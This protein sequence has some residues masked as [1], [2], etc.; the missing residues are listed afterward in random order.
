MLRFVVALEAE[1]RPLIE[2]YRL[3][4]GG[5]ERG[6]KTF[7]RDDV[8]LI[9]AGIG[10]VAAA[11]A[12]SRLHGVTGAER[13]AVWIN[14]GIA[15]HGTRPVAEAVLAHKV[16][17]RAS[18]RAWYPP[19][20]FKP[21]CA[22]DQVTTVD[23]PERAFDLPG[24]FEMEASGFVPSAGRFAS[25]E[26]VHCVKIVSDGHSSSLEG[27]TPEVVRRLVASQLSTVEA[28]AEAC[29]SLSRELRRVDAEA[30]ELG[31]CLERWH[32]T[33]TER[34]EL[35]RLLRRRRTLAPQQALPVEDLEAS[36]R[37]GEVN[38]R[39]HEWLNA[40]PVRIS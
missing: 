15:G 4:P 21:P 26:L 8:A 40:L 3:A 31:A 19:L 11:A 25:A 38:R 13:D 18:G 20:V 35:R 2:Q 37:G 10:K 32:F 14:V 16:V 39:L 27:L 28:V 22:T 5:G 34:R 30:P 29:A 36:A 1:A 17:D 7:R 12:V 23:R 9:V 33:V 6:F 24:A